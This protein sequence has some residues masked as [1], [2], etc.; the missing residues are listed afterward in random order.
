MSV[1]LRSAEQALTPVHPYHDGV[2]VAL[3]LGRAKISS[4]AAQLSDERQPTYKTRVWT[5]ASAGVFG[6][7]GS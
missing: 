2:L 6:C 1:T 5:F 7:A 4:N 3:Y